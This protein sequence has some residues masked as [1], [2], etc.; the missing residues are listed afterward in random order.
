[1]S[2]A[3]FQFHGFLFLGNSMQWWG[4]SDKHGWVVLDRS[5]PING[6][7]KGKNLLFFR[8]RDSLPYT[9]ER[10]NWNPPQ[11]RFAPNYLRELEPI[12]LELAKKQLEEFQARWPEFEKQIQQAHAA[13]QAA[14]SSGEDK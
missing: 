6:P 9:E 14:S 12:K 5:V 4:Y 10:K 3:G 1:M 13:N 2:A 11:Y 7:G 8:C